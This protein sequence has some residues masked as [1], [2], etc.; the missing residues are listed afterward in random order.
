MHKSLAADSAQQTTEAV[1]KAVL[2]VDDEQNFLSLLRWFLSNRGYDVETAASGEEAL[3]L[4]EARA[5]ELALIDIRMGPMDGLTLLTELKRRLPAI[6]VVIMTAYPTGGAIK[7][8][9]DK[10]AAAFLTKPVDLQEL[11]KTIHALF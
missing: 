1:G 5:F 2:V 10:G 6:R 4:V 8:S 7:Q 11:M 9:R 3:E